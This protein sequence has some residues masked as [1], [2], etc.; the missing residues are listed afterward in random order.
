VNATR[1]TYFS[2]NR[3]HKNDALPCLFPSGNVRQSLSYTPARQRAIRE[4]RQGE[5]WVY[6]G[7]V[8]QSWSDRQGNQ[9]NLVHGPE[10]LEKAVSPTTGE[11]L[12]YA[13]H[14]SADGI[15]LLD[16]EDTIIEGVRYSSRYAFDEK[17]RMT[18]QVV[19][20][21][22][23]A[24]CNHV[25]TE[26]ADLVY[27]N[28]ALASVNLKGG[29]E[30]YPTEGSPKVDWAGTIT[31]AYDANGRVTREDLAITSFNKT[32][33]QRPDGA[34]RDETSRL[35]VSMR[36][37]RPIENAIRVGDLCAT[38]GSSLLSNPIDLRPFY[39]ISPNLAMTLP[40]GVVRATVS[41]T[42]P[43]SFSVR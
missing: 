22:N 11:V 29:Y 8:L 5:G 16:R 21:Q 26:Q 15:W 33:M 14:K 24:A 18:Q 23:T 34:L 19:T 41:F 13:A 37:K 38:A 10:Y 1:T 39:A 3:L 12:E 27:Q 32:Y 30:G 17:G 25:I 35:Y 28:D 7:Q 20:Y 2:E 9:L 4:A 31:Y 42:Y 36:A 40:A 6:D 43:D